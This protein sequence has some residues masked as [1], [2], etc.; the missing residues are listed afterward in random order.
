MIRTTP[1][2]AFAQ[3]KR[4]API[5]TE[6]L[7]RIAAQP[8]TF[9]GWGDD[10]FAINLS[11]PTDQIAAN[12]L[13]L[14][15]LAERLASPAV[16]GCEIDREDAVMAAGFLMRASAAAYKSVLGEP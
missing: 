8:V 14:L 1:K 10:V 7:N 9:T 12:A 13:Y 4:G 2:T 11:A 5:T 15:E 16:K 6:E 3:P